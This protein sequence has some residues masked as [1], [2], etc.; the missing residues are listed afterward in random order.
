MRTLSRARYLLHLYFK[1][2]HLEAYQP[3]E[4]LF[5]G[6]TGGTHSARSAQNNIKDAAAK[7]LIKKY[8]IMHTLRHSFTT[9]CLENDIDL[10]YIKEMLGH[11]SIR[12]IE[13]YT[14]I[15]SRGFDK[16]KRPMDDL[17]SKKILG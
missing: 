3:K 14:H 8:V 5:E 16:I 2:H 10:C 11:E 7:A 12:A 1:A 9:H 6:F 17:A 13:I 4:Y 15:T